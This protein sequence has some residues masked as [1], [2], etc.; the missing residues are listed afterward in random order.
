MEDSK[1]GGAWECKFFNV[2]FLQFFHVFQIQDVNLFEETEPEKFT[3]GYIKEE[4]PDK[5]EILDFT[6]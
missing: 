1:I 2:F 4:L 6:Y 3:K 5:V